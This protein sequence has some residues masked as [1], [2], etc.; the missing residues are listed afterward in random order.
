MPPDELSLFLLGRTEGWTS[1][2]P[3]AQPESKEGAIISSAPQ[4]SGG[5][6]GNFGHIIQ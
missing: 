4:Q 1:G 3:Q 2:K 5:L 6:D